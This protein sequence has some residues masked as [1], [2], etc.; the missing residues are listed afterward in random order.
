[1]KTLS[2]WKI[3]VDRPLDMAEIV[4]LDR[5]APPADEMQGVE[6]QRVD[7]TPRRTAIFVASSRAGAK[8]LADALGATHAEASADELRAR[9]PAAE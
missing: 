2:L 5:Q 3:V 7:T 6:L 4:R 1:M 9:G 8:A